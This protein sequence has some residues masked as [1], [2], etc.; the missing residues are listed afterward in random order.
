MRLLAGLAATF[1]FA[2]SL[3]YAANAITRAASHHGP[4]PYQQCVTSVRDQHQWTWMT[5]TPQCMRLPFSERKAA[6][7]EGLTPTTEPVNV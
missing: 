5:P 1:A 4:S 2:F 6:I 3:T 7:R